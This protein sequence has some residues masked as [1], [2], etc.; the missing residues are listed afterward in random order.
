MQLLKEIGV[1]PESAPIVFQEA[2]GLKSGLV[3]CRL[4][5][6]IHINRKIKKELH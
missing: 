6:G 4:V 2:D 3:Q 5:S 1:E